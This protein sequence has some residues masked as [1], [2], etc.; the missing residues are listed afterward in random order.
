MAGGIQS[1]QEIADMFG[2]PKCQTGF[3][4]G[5]DN[6]F[7][8][9][10]SGVHRLFERSKKL[11]MRHS[12]EIKR[13]ATPK[14]PPA[15]ACIEQGAKARRFRV[16]RHFLGSFS[17]T[18]LACTCL[19]AL[20]AV[21]VDTPVKKVA[22][23]APV[24]LLEARDLTADSRLAATRRIPLVV[25]YTREDCSW[26]EKVR[27]EHLGPLSRDPATPALIREI[28]IDRAT[29]LIDF[30]GRRTTSAD[31]SREMKARLSPT[32]MFHAPDGK[33]LADPMVGFLLADFY[34]GYLERA[35]E[36][37]LSKLRAE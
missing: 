3:A 37:S 4:R 23:P 16:W 33:P 30:Q 8:G 18:I 35:I 2:L 36:E 24:K 32:V 28:Y 26:C 15:S 27:R 31:F 17:K 21:A 1:A 12:K 14:L 25:L 10:W 5:N 19:L 29:P 22:K 20:P 9:E 11:D 13:H 7:W 34:A 6:A